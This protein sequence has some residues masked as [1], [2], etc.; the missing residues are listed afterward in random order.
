M[1]PK[2]S[3]VVPAIAKLQGARATLSTITSLNRSVS[4]LDMLQYTHLRRKP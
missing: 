2:I 3:R 1:N 4:L